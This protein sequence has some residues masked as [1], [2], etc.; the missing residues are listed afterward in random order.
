[1]FDQI[2]ESNGIGITISGIIFIFLGLI[3]I[4]FV[5]SLFNRFFNK[6]ETQ[7][8][9]KDSEEKPVETTAISAI[10]DDELAA[11]AAAIE[12]YRRIHYTEMLQEITFKHGDPRSP[13]K[14]SYKFS[15]RNI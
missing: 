15:N 14:T 8:G 5:I 11:I 6:G 13:W 2:I 12:T 1:M 10:P 9:Q 3:L 4:A 7:Q